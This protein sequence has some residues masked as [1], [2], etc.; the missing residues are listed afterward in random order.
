MAANADDLHLAVLHLDADFDAACVVDLHPLLH[1]ERRRGK[2]PVGGEV[3]TKGTRGTPRRRILSSQAR[4]EGPRVD[5]CARGLRPEGE[6]IADDLVPELRQVFLRGGEIGWD[7]F[8]NVKGGDGA[9]EGLVSRGGDL[10]GEP[11][12]AD[13]PRPH[14]E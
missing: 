1:D 11:L 4:D 8:D 12:P 14:A 9:L 6:R 13:V 10:G 2:L 3:D 5:M 7:T